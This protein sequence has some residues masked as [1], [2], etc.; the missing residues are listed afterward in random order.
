MAQPRRFEQLRKANH[1]QQLIQNPLA[2]FAGYFSRQSLCTGSFV[3]KLLFT[4][5]M[6]HNFG[7][8]KPN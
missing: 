4:L 2:N 6:A 3:K 8:K 5:Q 1:F 7:G